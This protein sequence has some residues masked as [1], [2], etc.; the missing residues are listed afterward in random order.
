MKGGRTD[1]TKV[2]QVRGPDC[3]KK[4]RGGGID[5]T[6]IILRRGNGPY[7]KDLR[8]GETDLIKVLGGGDKDR[9]KK[10]LGERENRPHKL[11]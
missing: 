5:L 2:F 6:K 3:Q 9:A 7:Q 8:G 1:R 4:C 11:F 10:K